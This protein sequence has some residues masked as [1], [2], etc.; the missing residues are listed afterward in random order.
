MGKF[1]VALVA[2]VCGAGVITEP[3]SA[4]PISNLAATSGGLSLRVQNV[5]SE[6]NRHR[7]WLWPSYYDTPDHLRPRVFYGYEPHRHGDWYENLFGRGWGPYR[8]EWIRR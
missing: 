6:C 2:G 7:C 4:M 3:I 5:V 1:I 8:K